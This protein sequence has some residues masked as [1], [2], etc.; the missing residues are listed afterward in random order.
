[1]AQNENQVNIYQEILF[2]RG[3]VQEDPES[4][5]RHFDLGLLLMES[6]DYKAALESMKTVTYLDNQHGEAHFHQGL[7]FQQLSLL[8]SALAA[9]E[10]ALTLIPEN[11]DIWSNLALIMYQ[12]GDLTTSI[13]HYIKAAELTPKNPM[14]WQNLSYVQYAYGKYK[15]AVKSVK[16]ALTLDETEEN[17]GQLGL[18]LYADQQYQ[19]S[20]DALTVSL[21]MNDQQ[22]E[23]WNCLGSCLIQLEQHK[24]A[25]SAFDKAVNLTPDNPDYWFNLAEL[26]VLKKQSSEAINCLKRVIS[27]NE[28]DIEAL[29]LLGKLHVKTEP[30]EAI[31]YFEKFL[32]YTVGNKEILSQL[33]SLYADIDFKKTFYYRNQIK[34]LDPYDLDNNRCLVDLY[35]KMGAAEKAFDLILNNK[36]LQYQNIHNLNRLA[37]HYQ[38]KNMPDKELLC[39]EKILEL[40]TN[41][42]LS[43]QRL[44]EIAMAS[45]LLEKTANYFEK[46]EQPFQIALVQWKHVIRILIRT[47][48]WDT[49]IGLIKKILPS[50]QFAESFWFKIFKQLRQKKRLA[51]FT[52]Q[53]LSSPQMTAAPATAI[54]NFSELLHLFGQ[55]Q[56]AIDL[57][58]QVKNKCSGAL[59]YHLKL[60]TFF[61]AQKKYATV[62]GLL[63]DML[64]Q[65][66]AQKNIYYLLA[67]T[68]LN[69]NDQLNAAKTIQK[70]LALDETDDL[71]WIQLG[72]LAL[73]KGDFKKAI[74]MYEQA[75][76]H[77]KGDAAYRKMG[78]AFFEQ[79][80]LTE[81][82]T[83][84]Y[85][86]LA[87]N[88][89]NDLN[90]YALSKLLFA[91]E[92]LTKARRH[93]QY[94]L[95]KNRYQASYWQLAKTVF[96]G[97]KLDHHETICNQHLA[98]LV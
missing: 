52:N 13:L 23:I 86:A 72:D 46:I 87:F 26:H 91:E 28:R 10:L 36:S 70:G 22:P 74:T 62:V 34:N 4:P 69:Q 94:A 20:S 53:L 9:Y 88:R 77:H 63:T 32:E 44:G 98:E 25:Q 12:R 85:Q 7:C 19:E 79:G 97:L 38:F 27:I 55:T 78:L 92:D 59:T 49:A 1:M 65:F 18:S 73:S 64:D 42:G 61:G 81:A 41:H 51:F 15:D 6:G 90:H 76:T 54:I 5:D 45:D 75:L 48:R 67:E 24:S 47:E 39:I 16:H 58:S 11:A 71:F 60:A 29:S 68:Y 56:A 80:S 82:K 66:P 93:I 17:W 43:W 96:S 31:K 84:L 57:L 33:A 21:E 83:F 89:Y 35:L 30:H 8:D 3:R 2:R 37:Q 50:L 95:A 14:I 40:D